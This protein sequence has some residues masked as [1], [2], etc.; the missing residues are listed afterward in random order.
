MRKYVFLVLVS[1]LLVISSC[2]FMVDNNSEEYITK[3]AKYITGNEKS[4]NAD[5][6][7]KDG[8]IVAMMII[9]NFE[10]VLQQQ[11]EE[12]MAIEFRSKSKIKRGDNADIVFDI[13]GC[14]PN[15]NGFCEIFADIIAFDS[16][17]NI[18]FE[19]KDL[20]LSVGY[21]KPKKHMFF[22]PETSL[23]FTAEEKDYLGQY[24][25]KSKVKDKVSGKEH[26][27]SIKFDI[28]E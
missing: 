13:S 3:N 14:S 18:Y 5:F 10:D 7:N 2:Y 6:K 19:V 4:E 8:F 28:T 24:L 11:K 21:I 17:H 20:P 26:D 15:E 16:K 25:I 22:I 1:I 27:L 23:K 9:G 12:K